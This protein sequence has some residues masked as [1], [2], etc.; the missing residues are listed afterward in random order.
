M[1]T[2]LCRAKINSYN[3]DNDRWRLANNILYDL[4]RKYPKHNNEIGRAHV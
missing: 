3:D 1:P 4:V 2:D